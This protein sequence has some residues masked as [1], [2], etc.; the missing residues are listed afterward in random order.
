MAVEGLF[1]HPLQGVVVTSVRRPPRHVVEGFRA[2]YSAFVL[3]HVGKHGAMDPALRPLAPGMKLCGPA[4]T[5]LGPDLS[6]RRMAIDIA[7]P[8]DVLVVAAGAPANRACF[9]D[10][11][12]LRMTRKDLGGV[13][14]D[15]LTR[16]RDGVVQLGYPTFCRGATP[17]NFHYPEEG[18]HGA[19]N[20]P[21]VCGG[22]LVHPGDLILGDG[23]GIVVV[24]R[25]LAESIHDDILANLDQERAQR[26]A[27]TSFQPFGVETELRR[28][29]FRFVADAAD[30]QLPPVRA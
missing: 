9:G 24:E 16:D 19:V 2:V 15:G 20:V 14:I 18:D 17:R 8:G 27:M 13:V 1:R 28:R 7:E 26:Q 22:V 23:D 5:A 29:G 6:V 12:A 30:L 3:D 4:V 25:L 21:V 11:T 10:G